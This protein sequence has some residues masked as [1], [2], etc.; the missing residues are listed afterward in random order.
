M[1]KINYK[2]A[3]CAFVI[4]NIGKIQGRII[5]SIEKD[6]AFELE[7]FVGGL[8]NG[9]IAL[10]QVGNFIKTCPAASHSRYDSFPISL[11]IFNSHTKEVLA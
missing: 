10:H 1:I 2:I 3:I 5:R 4:N 9:K 7:G 11:I 6:I 8:L